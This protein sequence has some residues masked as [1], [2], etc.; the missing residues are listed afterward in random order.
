MSLETRIPKE[1]HDYREKIVFGLSAR[2]LAA[3]G[4]AAAVVLATGLPLYYLAG[5]DL[6]ILEYILILEAMPIIAVGFIRHK[7]LPFEKYA[8]IYLNHRFGEKRLIYKTDVSF[9]TSLYPVAPDRRKEGA[10]R[11]EISRK[12]RKRRKRSQGEL[13][14][15]APEPKGRRRGPRPQGNRPGEAP[16]GAQAQERA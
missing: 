7:G 11:R 12:E 1:I 9:L 16:R 13:L 2:Q 14:Q 5:I 10:G 8:R 15:G 3:L 4:A 6:K